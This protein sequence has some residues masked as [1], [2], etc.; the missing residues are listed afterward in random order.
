[1]EEVA[2]LF[3]PS[4]GGTYARACYTS[5]MPQGDPT[6]PISAAML[7]RLAELEATMPSASLGIGV[8]NL[9]CGCQN[10]SNTRTIHVEVN[11]T[12]EGIAHVELF[13]GQVLDLVIINVDGV[14]VV[15]DVCM[16]GKSNIYAPDGVTTGTGAPCKTVEGGLSTPPSSAQDMLEE[17]ILVEAQDLA[18]VRLDQPVLRD[19]VDR[20]VNLNRIAPTPNVLS[21]AELKSP[22]GAPLLLFVRVQGTG[23]CGAAG[24][25]F[26]VY[27]DR[28]SGYAQAASL[29]SLG[30]R[31]F[32]L[33]RADGSVSYFVCKDASTA[34]RYDFNAAT[35]KLAPAQS[36]DV[37]G[38]STCG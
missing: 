35:G 37:P 4:R 33:W 16:N 26:E 24:C 5:G 7:Q 2:A 11:D 38:F 32:V 28:G 12:G 23:F 18:G 25:T 14:L 8:G 10:S 19:L 27:A 22:A 3:Y 9:L 34:V 36:F 30:Q 6:C 21:M 1:M 17:I 31:S 20:V 15:D 13:L 29:L